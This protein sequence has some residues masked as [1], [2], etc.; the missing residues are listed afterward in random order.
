[1]GRDVFTNA[2]AI[3]FPAMIAACQ[4]VAAHEAHAETHATVGTAIF[5]RIGLATALAPNGKILAGGLHGHHAAFKETC[6]EPCD[7]PGSLFHPIHLRPD[8][9]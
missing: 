9:L 2:S 4:L 7:D 6:T 3:E 5:N 1:V 8:F